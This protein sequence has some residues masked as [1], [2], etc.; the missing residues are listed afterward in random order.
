[1]ENVVIIGSGLAGLTAAIY[2]ARAN[3]KPVLV[4]GKAEGGQLMLT[5]AVENYPGFPEGIMGPDLIDKITRQAKRFGTRF[6]DGDAEKVEVK[7]DGFETVTSEETI[8]SKSV[9]IASGASAR[10]LGL[11][12]EKKY[13]GNGVHT[14]ATCDSYAYGGKEVI[15]VGGG[16]S[17]MEESLF[18]AKHASKVTLVHRRDSFRASR[19]MQDRLS[20]NEKIGV[21]LNAVVQEVL[22]DGTRVAGVKVR[23]VNTDEVK[24]LKT[25]AVFLA[26]GHVPNTKFLGGLVETDGQGFI[27]TNKTRT[28]VPGLF[29]CGDVQ[30]PRYKQAVTAA[31]S[32]CQAAMEAE[33]YVESLKA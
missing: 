30:D 20:A 12:S 17:A 32:G 13:L 10:M 3:L 5:T 21:I 22:G 26:I 27:L 23:D 28:K 2:N 19:I 11:D 24:E 8:K 9:I 25:D 1:M 31:G 4:S 18:I 33:R 16:D 6:V 29:A 14:C 15:V 7:G